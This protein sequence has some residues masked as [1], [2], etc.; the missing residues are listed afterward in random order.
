MNPN[1]ILRIVDALHR[2]KNIDS[3]LVF[4][5][6]ESAMASA[7]RRQRGDEAEIAVSIDRTSGEI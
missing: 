1:E 2:D 5:A 3:E 7:I 4:Q 6:I